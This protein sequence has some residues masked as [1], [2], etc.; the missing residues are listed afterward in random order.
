MSVTLHLFPESSVLLPM[1]FPRKITGKEPVCIIG[2]AFS[3]CKASG[4]LLCNFSNGWTNEV[5]S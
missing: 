2:G 3:I 4:L 5:V 1:S